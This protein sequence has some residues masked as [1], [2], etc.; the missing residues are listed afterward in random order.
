MTN[1]EILV[2]F[3]SQRG[4]MQVCNTIYSDGAVLYLQVTEDTFNRLLNYFKKDNLL[5][6]KEEPLR[7]KDGS[8]YAIWFTNNPLKR[9]PYVN[10]KEALNS[11]IEISIRLNAPDLIDKRGIGYI[12]NRFLDENTVESYVEL[13]K[14][15]VESGEYLND[16]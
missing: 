8:T 5:D 6:I 10:W 14:P 12:D 15:L 1:T 11:I 9:P 2:E 3:Y 13:I 7:S 4:S 16:K